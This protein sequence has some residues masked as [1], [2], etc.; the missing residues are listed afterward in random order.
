MSSSDV[1]MRDGRSDRL[2]RVL[3]NRICER[4]F[5]GDYPDGENLPPE[6]TLAE[7]LDISR[8][9]VRKAL[10]LLEADGIIE[11][12]Q[13]S[14]NRVRLNLAGHC[15]NT[16]IIAVLARAQNAFF[17]SFIDQF[18]QTAE[19]S[20]SLVLFKQN[21]PGKRLEES[22]FKLLQKDIRNAVIWLE[23]QEID[24]EAIR[25]LRGLGMNMVF[26][27]AVG[28]LPY[29]DGVLL[30]NADAI[31]NLYRLLE[32][33]GEKHIAYVGWDNDSI[34][35][36]REREHAFIQQKLAPARIFKIP[37]HDRT[38]LNDAAARIVQQLPLAEQ[39]TGGIVCG[40]G[41]IGVAIK[42]A[43]NLCKLDRIKVAS[44]D[45]YPESLALSIYVYRQDF[46][47]MAEQ[48]YQCLSQQ[49]QPGWRASTY[50]IKGSCVTA[51]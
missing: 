33:K 1:K 45:E 27:D 47:R 20:D 18:Q 17:A 51:S 34:L 30:D 7:S 14:G 12:V 28:P 8:I 13:G 36:A 19:N 46:Q 3:E 31:T 39:A 15:G 6:R 35:S 24:M 42:K 2:Y 22:L 4:I 49:N 37:W 44:P 21:P 38:E 10:A 5:R 32:E 23:D 50:R 48:V 41:E 25:R 11:R 43:L 29:A 9:T 26:F 16:D 40:D